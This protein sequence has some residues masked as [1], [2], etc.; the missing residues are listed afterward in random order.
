MKK[1]LL[2]ASLCC[3]L[4]SCN[5]NND[6]SSSN[7]NSYSSDDEQN[8]D[9][10]ITTKVK[11][12]LMSDSTISASARLVSVSTTDGVVT[13]TGTVESQ[14]EAYYIERKVK[15]VAGVKKVVNDLTVGS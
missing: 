12:A 15:G 7:K 4:V 3:T 2:F 8:P 5:S 14:D 13:L 10:Q 6:Y 9:W 1:F 11:A